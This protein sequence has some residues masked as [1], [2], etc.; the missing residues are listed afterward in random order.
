[1]ADNVQLPKVGG[2]FFARMK[3]VAANIFSAIP[4]IGHP[5]TGDPFPVGRASE[6]DTL[7][8]SIDSE[9]FALLGTLN[10]GVA[11][12]AG[13]LTA[14]GT[15]A[16]ADAPSYVEGSSNNPLSADT[17]GALRAL[18]MDEGGEPVDLTASQP[19]YASPLGP[20]SPRLA[21]N[22]N[23]NAQLIQAAGGAGVF[24]DLIGWKVF[25]P[26]PGST[27]VVQI[28]DD[29]TVVDELVIAAGA[30]E[31]WIDSGAICEQAVANKA[32]NVKMPSSAVAGVI[33]KAFFRTR[34][35]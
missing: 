19:V 2:S 17:N 24:Y 11:A 1:M 29:T 21:M 33:V 15:K 23:T 35:A 34:T 31:G 18:I 10:T 12:L 30:Q 7:S 22:N 14:Y 25:N 9:A 13:I 4:L 20:K 27:V 8:F 26:A 28:L 32:W 16:T 5:D 6:A 3:E